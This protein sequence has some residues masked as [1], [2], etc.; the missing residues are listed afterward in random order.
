MNGLLPFAVML[1]NGRFKQASKT[2][3]QDHQ[4]ASANSLL[5]PGAANVDGR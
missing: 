3:H 1:A 2:T 5:S 4:R